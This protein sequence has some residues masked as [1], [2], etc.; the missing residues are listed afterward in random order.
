MDD[1]RIELTVLLYLAAPRKNAPTAGD[2]LKSVGGLLTL[3]K[4]QAARVNEEL[5]TALDRLER[6]GEV[7]RDGRQLRLSL[8]GQTRCAKELG[9]KFPNRKGWGTLKKYLLARALAPRARPDEAL[10]RL[11]NTEDVAGLVVNQREQCFPSRVPTATQV[12]DSLAWRELG[13]NAKTKPSWKAAR[14]LLLARVLGV[15]A[16]ASEG[17]FL[18]LLAARSLG[19]NSATRAAIEAKVL[20]D[21]S[22]ASVVEQAEDQG[23]S[24]EALFAEQVLAAASDPRTKRFGDNKAFIASVFDSY[25]R[26]H[27]GESFREF[28]SRLVEAHLEGAL[29][30]A[31]ADLVPAMDRELVDRSELNY[32]NATFHFLEVP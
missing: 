4:S 9:V 5:Q 17:A 7:V 3:E 28:G 21:W 20:A 24:K 13:G 12:A 1:A 25:K 2:V 26:Q 14:R 27:D 11:S 30:L 31:R 16:T 6:G 15:P 32:E 23:R 18:R 22:D 29:R 10:K 8:A 19:A